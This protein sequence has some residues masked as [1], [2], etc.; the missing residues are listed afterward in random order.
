MRRASGLLDSGQPQG[1]EL[2]GVTLPT[3]TII[4]VAFY[5]GDMLNCQESIGILLVDNE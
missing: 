5:G 2:V 4:F 1:I 3:R